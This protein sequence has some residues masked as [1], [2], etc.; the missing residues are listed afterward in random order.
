MK[1]F[2]Y[3]FILLAYF[4]QYLA[5]SLVHF[6]A[7]ICWKL[8]VNY[9]HICLFAHSRIFFS[10]VCPYQTITF[11]NPQFQPLGMGIVLEFVGIKTQCESVYH[12]LKYLTTSEWYEGR[13]HSLANGNMLQHF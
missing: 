4:I 8:S 7:I 13:L 12:N 2:S 1:G 10:F 3:S 5:S 9:V 11:S 6:W